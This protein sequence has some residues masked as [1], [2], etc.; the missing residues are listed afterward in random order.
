M[1]YDR[2][3][4]IE[5]LTGSSFYVFKECNLLENIEH[6]KKAFR[7]Y[8]NNTNFGYSYKTNHLPAACLLA[9]NN[10]LYSEVVSPLELELTKILSIAPDNIIYNGPIIDTEAISYVVRNGGMVNIDNIEQLKVI[11]Q[12]GTDRKHFGIRV[13]LDLEDNEESR[14]GIDVNSGEFK[15]IITLVNNDKL[16]RVNGLHFHATRADKSSHMFKKRLSKLVDLSRKVDMLK[17]ISYM[18]IGGGIYGPMDENIKKQFSGTVPGYKEYAEDIAGTMK[19]Y[20][21][22]EKVKLIMEPGV[23]LTVNTMDFYTK[24][25]NI[26]KLNGRT[27]VFTDASFFNVKPTGHKKNLSTQVFKKG[28]S[29]APAK[30][31]NA[32]LTGCTC[33]EHDILHSGYSGEHLE[34][35]D[36]IAFRNVGAYS[37]VFKPPFIETAPPV[38]K[39]ENDNVILLRKK[40]EYRDVYKNYII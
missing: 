6:I 19:K 10:G 33:L 26:K 22:E 31:C 13:N 29:P 20:Y 28:N 8:Y 25:K 38:I 36:F 37:F 15:E 7:S 17:N 30:D 18:N 3:R 16:L 14:F 21:P 12:L 35:N 32:I 40:E 34:I 11:A 5:E 2:L 9:H 24:I 39:M 27:Y 23:G 1:N 4:K